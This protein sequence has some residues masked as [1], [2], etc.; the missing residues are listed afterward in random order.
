MIKSIINKRVLIFSL[1]GLLFILIISLVFIFDNSKGNVAE[2]GG[3]EKLPGVNSVEVVEKLPEVNA[4]EVVEKLPEVNAVEVVEK[5]SGVNSV[6]SGVVEKPS[7]EVNNNEYQLI[8]ISIYA[9]ATSLALI[10]SVL[11]SIHLYRWRKISLSKPDTLVPKEWEKVLNQVSLTVKQNQLQSIDA[12]SKS[13]Y[14]HEE[15]YKNSE[16]TLEAFMSLHKAMDEKDKEIERLKQGYDS[17]IYKKFLKR[18]LKTYIAAKD[19]L[20]ED[21]TNA[22]LKEA[23]D[24]LSDALQECDVEEF[25]PRIGDDVRHAKGIADGPRIIDTA[26]LAK[27]FAIAEIIDHGYWVRGDTTTLVILEAKVKIYRMKKEV[28]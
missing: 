28:I 1:I 21:P 4:V 25:E 7:T 10:L 13:Q 23:Q 6:E 22:S 2:G 17:Y 3:V 16:K 15:V 27:D 26:D 5:L 12:R 9:I 20:E 18:F 8:T 24:M 19:M 11:L 14:L